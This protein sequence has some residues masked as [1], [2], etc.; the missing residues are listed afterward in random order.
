VIERYSKARI[1]YDECITD[2]GSDRH[3][4]LSK[5]RVPQATQLK[6]TQILTVEFQLDYF[7]HPTKAP[8]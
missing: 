8:K 4:V 7:R 6:V 5:V 1:L 2:E 3:G